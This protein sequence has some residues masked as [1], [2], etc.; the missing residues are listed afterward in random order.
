MRTK[1]R[2]DKYKINRDITVELLTKQ[3]L[4]SELA[5][6]ANDRNIEAVTIF[7]PWIYGDVLEV[8]CRHGLLLE[9]LKNE[10]ELFLDEIYGIDISSEAVAMAKEK[11]ISGRSY[12]S[13]RYGRY[14]PIA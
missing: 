7:E 4:D 1:K 2:I 10:D 14:I 11:R 8:G 13:R 9:Y 5:K 12:G 3:S 6:A